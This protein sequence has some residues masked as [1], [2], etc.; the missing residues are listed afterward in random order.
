[1]SDE[2]QRERH[3]KRIYEEQVKI[4]KQVSIAKQHNL[5]VDNTV[6]KQPHRL[7]KRHAMNCGNPQCFMCGNPRKV[8][9]EPT[10]QERRFDQKERGQD[11]NAADC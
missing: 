2:V 3:S 9:K 10:I 6:I 8:F 7:A 4:K 5:G 1:M 11:G